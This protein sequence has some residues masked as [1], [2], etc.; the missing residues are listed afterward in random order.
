MNEVNVRR[1]PN[2]IPP[3]DSELGAGWEQPDPNDLKF[4]EEVSGGNLFVSIDADDLGKLN[5]YE[6]L[7]W[8]SENAAGKMWRKDDNLMWFYYENPGHVV[9]TAQIIKVDLKSLN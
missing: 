4:F 8:V 2:P 1:I 3:I 6:P 5:H 7:V 9:K